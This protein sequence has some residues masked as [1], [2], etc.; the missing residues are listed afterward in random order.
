MSPRRLPARSPNNALLSLAVLG[1]LLASPAWAD[2]RDEARRHFNTGLELVRQGAYEQGVQEFLAAYDLSPHPAVLYNVARAYGD[3]GHYP[4]AIDYFERYLDSDPEDRIQVEGIMLALRQQLEAQRAVAEA[5]ENPEPASE[6][7]QEGCPEGGAATSAEIE[8]LQRVAQDL[9]ALAERLQARGVAQTPA[10]DPVAEVE[11]PAA[12]VAPQAIDMGEQ[13]LVEDLYDRV[14]VTAAR[15]G[16]APLEAPSAIT[17]ITAEQIR[18]TPAASV[19]DLLR[20]VPGLDVMQ[21]AAGQSE[22]AIR[23]FNRRLSNKV[24]VLIDGRSVYLD[25]LGSTL[26]GSLPITLDEIERIEIIRGAGSAMYGANAFSGV[27]NIIT[28]APGGP[29]SR[30]QLSAAMGSTAFGQGSL[31]LSGRE[32][33]VAWRASMGLDRHGRWAQEMDLD[34]RPDYSSPVEDQTL[35]LDTSTVNAQVDWRLPRRAFVSLSGGLNTGL[36]EFYAIGTLGDF[37]SQHRSAYLRTDAGMGPL[38]L[39]AF[40]NHFDTDTG[41]WYYL[42]GGYDLATDVVSDVYDLDLAGDWTLGPQERHRITSS[43]GYRYKEISWDYLDGDHQEHHFNAFVQ[44][45]SHLGPVVGTLSMRVDEHPLVGFTPSPRLAL[46]THLGE[47]RALRLNG[48]TAF[49]TPTFMES[50]LSLDQRIDTDAVV[51]RTVGDTQLEPERILAFEA[52]YLEHSSDWWRGEASGYYY[53]ITDLID[54][55]SIE[56]SA[57]HLEFDDEAGVYRAGETSFINEEPV[58]H[59]YGGELAVDFFG[60]PGLDVEASYAL[61]LIQAASDSALDRVESTPVHKLNAG[62]IYRSPWRVDGSMRA[63]WIDKQVWPIREFDA[64]GQ[65]Q[66]TDSPLPGWVLLSNRVV[67]H[68]APEQR[69]DLV[70]DAWNWLALIESIGPHAEHPLGQPVA[71][72]LS[73]GLTARF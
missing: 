70:L 29:G 71:A 4:Q 19:A 34:E 32:G 14:V 43:L 30:N 7:Q 20:S 33:D 8:Q 31:L 23:G 27:V 64:D 13:G 53:R 21:L 35:A 22:V 38:H 49:R 69:L 28:H 9:G 1:L 46:V 40:W 25:F 66:V 45:E 18:M 39:R 56:T 72:R 26:W 65:V 47:G 57:D 59:A 17:V 68:L 62:V 63:T 24:L 3:A 12:Q 36:E 54:L 73:G 11:P 60:L 50:Y 6:P 52:G 42:L 58:Y 41:A 44:D 5:I 55:G 10:P 61:E 51:V 16:Q 48:G 67:L 2:P 15:Y 37:V